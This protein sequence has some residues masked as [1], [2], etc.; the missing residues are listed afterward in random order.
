[1]KVSSQSFA[2]RVLAEVN[3]EGK[4]RAGSALKPKYQTRAAASM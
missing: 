2:K 4:L 1:V 3:D